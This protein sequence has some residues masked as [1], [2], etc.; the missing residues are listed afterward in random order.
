MSTK[1]FTKGFSS[2]LIYRAFNPIAPEAPRHR[3]QAP[4]TEN[5]IQDPNPKH[6]TTI[7]E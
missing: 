4:S 3:A 7:N 5:P 2:M 6:R 1:F